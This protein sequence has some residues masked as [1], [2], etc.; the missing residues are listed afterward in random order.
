M[1]KLSRLY[2]DHFMICFFFSTDNYLLTFFYQLK[3]PLNNHRSLKNSENFANREG[4]PQRRRHH[5]ILI[6]IT[7]ITE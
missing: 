1:F 3:I 7:E 2:T 4:N 5:K 6:A